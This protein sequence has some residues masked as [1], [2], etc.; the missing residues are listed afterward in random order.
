MNALPREWEYD[1]IERTDQTELGQASEIVRQA[2]YQRMNKE[3]PYSVGQETVEWAML[4]NGSL[5][6]DQ[7]LLVNED[8]HKLIVGAA[9]RQIIEKAQK[10]LEKTFGRKVHLYLRVKTRSK[11]RPSM[12]N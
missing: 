3:L 2:V 10:N 11:N 12:D 8:H 5:R 9:L 1:R 7:M 4:R 6:L